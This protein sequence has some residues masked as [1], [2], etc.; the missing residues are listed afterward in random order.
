MAASLWVIEITFFSVNSSS[1]A[2]Q[3]SRIWNSN[4]VSESIARA[5]LCDD[6]ARTASEA[7]SGGTG[8]T[9]SGRAAKSSDKPASSSERR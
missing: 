4:S 6:E 7:K 3:A 9:K 5:M 8:E 1:K 2:T